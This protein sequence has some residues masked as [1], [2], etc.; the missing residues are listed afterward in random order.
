MEYLRQRFGEAL[1]KVHAEEDPGS[2]RED[3]SLK[4]DRALG[5]QMRL[6]D[7]DK[8]FQCLLA[9]LARIFG[10][11]E[12]R[13]IS[14][15]ETDFQQNLAHLLLSRSPGTGRVSPGGT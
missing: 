4:K 3:D 13:I 5:P 2:L 10:L 1:K 6:M 11:W 7:R 8:T 15:A 12:Q 9:Q 14:Y